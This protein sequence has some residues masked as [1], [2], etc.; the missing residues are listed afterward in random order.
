[1]KI[2]EGGRGSETGDEKENIKKEKNNKSKGEVSNVGI[3]Y[4]FS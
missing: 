1:M 2:V 4:N 3:V